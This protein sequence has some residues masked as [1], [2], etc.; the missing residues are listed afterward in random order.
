M[1]LAE[2]AYF[3][4]LPNLDAARSIPY[5][6]YQAMSALMRAVIAARKPK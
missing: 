4:R 5:G 2:F 3:W 1:D 6:D